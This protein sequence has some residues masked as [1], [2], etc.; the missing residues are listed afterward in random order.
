VIGHFRSNSKWQL[1]QYDEALHESSL[2]KT[3][4]NDEIK[5]HQADIEKALLSLSDK[6]RV[7]LIMH[8]YLGYKHTEISELTG[9][10]IG[11]SKTHLHRAKAQLKA[12]AEAALMSGMSLQRAN[13][14]YELQAQMVEYQQSHIALM[15]QQHKAVRA[16]FVSFIENQ[17]TPLNA[18]AVTEL[19]T[20]LATFDKASTQLKEALIAQP[21][22]TGYAATLADTYQRE[23]ELLNKIKAQATRS[24]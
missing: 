13:Q 1:E 23:A 8:D 5:A 18:N 3:G 4:Q 7:V 6:A 17:N 10:A 21:T 11:T 12:Q 22:N 15:E 9:M 16:Q 24:I 2:A 19:R 14:T 20:T